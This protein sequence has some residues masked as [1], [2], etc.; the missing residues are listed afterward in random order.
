[1]RPDGLG[2]SKLISDILI[3]AKMPQ[4]RKARVYVP[5]D[6]DLTT[7]LCGIRPAEGVKGHRPAP[8]S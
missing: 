3:D 6:R 8:T 5:A 1:M 4:D 7:R 2:G